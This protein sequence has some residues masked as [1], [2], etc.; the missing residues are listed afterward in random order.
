M[1]FSPSYPTS[2]HTMCP[3]SFRQW[4]NQIQ[5][6]APGTNRCLAHNSVHT[7]YY[8]TL[9][10]KVLLKTNRNIAV[11]NCNSLSL[12]STPDLKLIRFLLLSVDYSTYL[13]HQR[14]CSRLT[15][16]WHFII[17]VLLILLLFALN[18]AA[19]LPSV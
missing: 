7:T 9:T 8:F 10:S 18:C 13:L 3:V 4:C 6:K 14:L 5:R 17:I 16:L 19:S 1:A 12:L 15:A 11:L 2:C